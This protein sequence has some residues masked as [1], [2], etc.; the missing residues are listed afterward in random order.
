MPGF[1]G[2]FVCLFFWNV[3]FSVKSDKIDKAE[4]HSRFGIYMFTYILE[5]SFNCIVNKGI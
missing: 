3:Q 1:G 2:L 4:L 5:I